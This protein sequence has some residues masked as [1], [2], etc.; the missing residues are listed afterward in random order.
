MSKTIWIFSDMMN[1]APNFP[2][3]ML[4]AV[5]PEQMLERAKANGLVVPLNGYKIYIL[6]ASPNG[7]AP[8]AWRVVKKFWEMYFKAAGAELITYST[9]CDFERER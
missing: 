2:M 6:G 7:L 1:E 3:P 8:Q 9:E 5:G 4:I